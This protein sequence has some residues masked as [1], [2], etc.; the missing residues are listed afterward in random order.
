M[1]NSSDID[2]LILQKTHSEANRKWRFLT[3][4]DSTNAEISRCLPDHPSEEGLVVIADS[5][6]GGKGRQG[7]VWHSEPGTG[8]YISTLIRPNLPPEQLPILTLMAGLATAMAVNDFIPQPAQLKWPNDLLLNGKKVAG[9]LCE[10]HSLE[11][12]A[13]IIGIGIN[14]NQNQFPKDIKNIATSL[15]LESGTEI[16][17]TELIKNL[18]TQLDHQYSELVENKI[19]ALIENWT[20]HTDLFGKTIT[21][22]KSNQSITGKATRLDEQGRLVLIN[23][24]GEEQAYDSGE[25][26]IVTPTSE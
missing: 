2:L 10:Y 17:R 6:T 3:E 21:L 22:N 14:V 24:S 19:Q 5:Q 25:V 8:I 13:V 11:I 26:R 16:N 1:P 23:A 20:R 15:K 9:V 12:P 18:I 7:R 4:T